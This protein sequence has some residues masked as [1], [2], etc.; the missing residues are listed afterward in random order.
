MARV[1]TIDT[2][3]TVSIGQLLEVLVG[4]YQCFGIFR[5]ITE[6]YIIVGKTVT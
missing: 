2:V 5:R 6:M 4:L 1:A 3:I